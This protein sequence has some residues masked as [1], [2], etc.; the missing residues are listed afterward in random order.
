MFSKVQSTDIIVENQNNIIFKARSADICEI[1]KSGSKNIFKCQSYSTLEL[2]FILY[3]KNTCATCSEL[4]RSMRLFL[5]IINSNVP[6]L[7]EISWWYFMV[8][9]N[10][11]KTTSL[12]KFYW[13]LSKKS[14]FLTIVY[15]FL[16]KID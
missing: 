5:L 1:H 3:Y 10:S 11:N 14:V 6:S 8:G 15:L 2:I 12:D 16:S 7:N 4:C 13:Y 9:L